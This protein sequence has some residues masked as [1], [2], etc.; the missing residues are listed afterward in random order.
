MERMNET[1]YRMFT[2][3]F[4]N[5]ITTDEPAVTVG[6]NAFISGFLSYTPQIAD[7]LEVA[8][9]HPSSCLPNAYAGFLWLLLESP[10]GPQKAQ[11]FIDKALAVVAGV[12]PREALIVKIAQAWV[13]DDIS[14]VIQACEQILIAHPRDLAI[15]KLAQYHLFNQ[16]DALNMLRLA[17]LC[18]AANKDVSHMH[19]MAAF[20][21]EQCHLLA[22]AERAARAALQIEPNN[23]WAHHALAHVFLTRG[24]IDEG[25]AFLEGASASWAGL[26]SFMYTHNWWHL[27]VFYINRGKMD[28]AL[29][30][31]DE[32]L[33]TQMKDYSQDQIGAVSMLSRLE[34]AGVDV[35]GRWAEPGDFIAARGADTTQPF[36]SLQYLLGLKKAN[37]PEADIMMQAIAQ[38]ADL[39]TDSDCPWL[40]VALPVSKGIAA[41]V[42]GDYGLAAKHFGLSLPHLAEIGGSHAQRDLFEQLYLEALLKSEH[43]SKA[44]QI[45]EMRRTYDP[46][47]VPINRELSRIYQRCGLSVLAEDRAHQ[48]ARSNVMK[49]TSHV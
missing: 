11:P 2:D 36:L 17:T 46:L 5:K 24:Q 33:W 49:E 10:E 15:L 38:K 21:Y 32:H 39:S 28:A 3:L 42:D 44:Q 20:A 14:T 47:S 7:V 26:N 29:Q 6:I 30:I 22:E 48:G 4:G 16:G 1:K 25:A 35:G 23:P 34:M 13:Q 40:R 9:K 19:A 37:R 18:F 8:Q 45:L 27:A 12:S 43:W 31:Y 41:L